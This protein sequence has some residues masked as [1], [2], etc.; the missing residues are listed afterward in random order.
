LRPR[1]QQN[2]ALPTPGNRV[3]K[4]GIMKNL[5]TV[6]VLLL[7]APAFATLPKA[8]CDFAFK[9]KNLCASLVWKKKPVPVEAPTEKDQAEFELHFWNPITGSAKGPYVSPGNDVAV[10][11]SMP[12][13]PEMGQGEPTNVQSGAT[14]VYDVSR[15]YFTMSGAWEIRVALKQDGKTG[16]AAKLKYTLK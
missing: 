8:G 3:N 16:D 6:S 11:V 4:V 9:K 14:G 2:A 10:S 5:I 13:M 12:S 1:L 7:S 15:V